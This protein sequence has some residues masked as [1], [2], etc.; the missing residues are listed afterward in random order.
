M[1]PTKG[2][3]LSELQQADCRAK[4]TEGR[5]TERNESKANAASKRF[6]VGADVQFKKAKHVDDS[7]VRRRQL[8]SRR[9]DAGTKARGESEKEDGSKEAHPFDR[10]SR[11]SVSRIDDVRGE[12]RRREEAEGEKKKVGKT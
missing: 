11:S 9:Q 12:L 7:G 4:E 10:I 8:H 1:R 3:H 5:Q 2:L 6:Q